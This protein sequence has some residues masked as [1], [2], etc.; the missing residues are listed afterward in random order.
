MTKLI[1]TCLSL[2]TV[3]FAVVLPTI[4]LQAAYAIEGTLISA[5]ELDARLPAGYSGSYIVGLAA[6]GGIITTS[7]VIYSYLDHVNR[8]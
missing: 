6:L 7:Y 4:Y 2:G 1:V 3:M 8:G 5:P